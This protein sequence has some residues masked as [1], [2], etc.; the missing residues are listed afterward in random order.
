MPS[1]CGRAMKPS[2]GSAASVRSTASSR[3]AT[4]C[5]C[6]ARKSPAR[7]EVAEDERLGTA[8]W[9]P[10]VRTGSMSESSLFTAVNFDDRATQ[11]LG[12][13]GEGLGD[14]L[15]V[16]V[17]VVE[18]RGGPE[19]EFVVHEAGHRL[20]HD[21]AIV[22]GAVVAGVV[23]R[24]RVASQVRGEQRRGVGR[25]D[26]R[27][28]RPGDQRRRGGR[29]H[30][31]GRADDADDVGVGDDGLR[32]GLPTV[33]GAELVEAGAEFHVE[34]VDRT[35]VGDGQLN[36]TLVGKSQP[37]DIARDGIERADLDGVAVGDLHDTERA[38]AALAVR[39]GLGRVAVAA[40]GR[41]QQGGNRQR[42]PQER[43]SS[44]LP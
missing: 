18:G 19:S 40:A 37:G 25:R 23:I 13:V 33:A 14:G 11:R 30:R 7:L 6:S 36:A 24:P 3:P 4:E 17:A 9:R 28:A 31:A 29:R 8:G 32:R 15:A 44:S 22:G 2:T 27:H 16:R 10:T 12:V 38:V 1:D 26:H 20:A 43:S 42:A 35:E 5:N 21:Q 41:R 34:A 39:G